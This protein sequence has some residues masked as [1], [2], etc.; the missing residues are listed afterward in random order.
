VFPALDRTNRERERE[1]EREK[2]TFPER[3]KDILFRVDVALPS[4][5]LPCCCYSSSNDDTRGT[6]RAT[7]R[8]SA[9]LPFRASS[10]AAL[11]CA[12]VCVCA[13]V[14]VFFL[15]FFS[16][17]LCGWVGHSDAFAESTAENRRNRRELWTGEYLGF[18]ISRL[19]RLNFQKRRRDE[20]PH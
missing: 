11:R 15:F 3:D 10:R 12:L 19:S 20:A 9:S 8:R 6:P 13:C 4:I 16:A 7:T 1:T 5:L 18:G 2:K 17:S 14:R